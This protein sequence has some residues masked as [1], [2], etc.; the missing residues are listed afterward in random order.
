MT[1]AELERKVRSVDRC[2]AVT[3]LLIA[4]FAVAVLRDLRAK[5]ARLDALESERAKEGA[6]DDERGD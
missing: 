5:D 2:L 4:I 1:N 6:S 3:I